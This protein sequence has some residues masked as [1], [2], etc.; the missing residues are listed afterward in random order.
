MEPTTRCRR[1][2]DVVA[3]EVGSQ[4]ML[5]NVA[6]WTYLHFNETGSKIWTALEQSP[7]VERLV[8]SLVDEYAVDLDACRNDVAGFLSEMVA[9]GFVIAE[10]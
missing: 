8:S 5:L 6:T 2:P 4:T 7:T 3:A 9:S 10:A 1:N